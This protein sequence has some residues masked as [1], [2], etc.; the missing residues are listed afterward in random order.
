[1]KPEQATEYCQSDPNGKGAEREFSVNF[2]KEDEMAYV[3]STISSQCKR[4]LNHSDVSVDRI[5]VYN[6]DT[7]VYSTEALSDFDGKGG[8]IIWGVHGRVPIESLK[9]QSSP[10]SQRSYANVV[11]P[12]TEVNFD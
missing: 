1:M 10:R 8:E 12:Q 4:L 7:E 5:S 2:T 6:K 9:I 3:H 11:S